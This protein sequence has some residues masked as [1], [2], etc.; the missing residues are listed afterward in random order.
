[1]LTSLLIRPREVCCVL[2]FGIFSALILLLKLKRNRI[3]DIRIK[4]KYMQFAFPCKEELLLL[5]GYMLRPRGHDLT[6][7]ETANLVG[8]PL[9]FLM[10]FN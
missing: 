9:L 1:M 3:S 5:T 2:M 4:K 10:L 6:I 8:K 7:P